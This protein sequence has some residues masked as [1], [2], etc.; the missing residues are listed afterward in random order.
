MD[1]I[2][3]QL[4]SKYKELTKYQAALERVQDSYDL[5]D[6]SREEYLQRRSKWDDKI[7]GIENEIMLLE[8]QLKSQE[9]ISDEERLHAITYF[10]ENIDKIENVEDRNKLY[11]T[12]LDSVVWKRIGENEPELEINFL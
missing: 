11:K 12:L 5:G 6:Y 7:S 3:K 8:K 9:Q 10:L 2:T 1:F 4:Q